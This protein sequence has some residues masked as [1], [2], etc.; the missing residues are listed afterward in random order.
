MSEE[1][2]AKKMAQYELELKLD[3]M[4]QRAFPSTA[5]KAPKKPLTTVDVEIIKEYNKQ[6]NEPIAEYQYD[7]DEETGEKSIR[8]LED[9]T[10]DFKKTLKKFRVVP[11]PELDV[12]DDRQFF[13]IPTKDEIEDTYRQL[14]E[15][16]EFLNAANL[17]VPVLVKEKTFIMRLIDKLPSPEQFIFERL[18]DGRNLRTP[19]PNYDRQKQAVESEKARMLQRIKGIGDQ[20]ARANEEIKNATDEYNALTSEYQKIESYKALNDAEIAKDAV[21]AFSTDALVPTGMI[22]A[23]TEGVAGSPFEPV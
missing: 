12:V 13:I 23:I 20:M 7:I 5:Q 17:A 6:F 16:K 11:P 18:R 9:G 22:F 3:R 2:Q 8:L 10:P 21:A 1:D 4:T 19:N 15:V 14:Q